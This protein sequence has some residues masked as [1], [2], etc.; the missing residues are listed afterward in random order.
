MKYSEAIKL[1]RLKMCLTQ[2]GWVSD[3]FSAALV[4]FFSSA[5]AIN[6]N[7]F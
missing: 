5:T 6:V 4:K 2:T 3:N 1:L 7:N